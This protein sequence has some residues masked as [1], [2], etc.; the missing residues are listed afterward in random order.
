VLCA[1]LQLLLAAGSLP[2]LACLGVDGAAE[3][4]ALLLLLLLSGASIDLVIAAA[5]AAA[6]AGAGG[7]PGAG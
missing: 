3:S 1:L 4:V 5:A 2:L 6:A 7:A